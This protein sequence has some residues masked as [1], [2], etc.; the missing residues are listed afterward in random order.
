MQAHPDHSDLLQWHFCLPSLY[1]DDCFAIS[2]NYSSDFNYSGT[3][4]T[5][6]KVMLIINLRTIGGSTIS[7]GVNP[8]TMGG[9]GLGTL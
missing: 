8:G 3:T 7:Q 6:N 1:I 2:L 4:T 5:D 9:Y